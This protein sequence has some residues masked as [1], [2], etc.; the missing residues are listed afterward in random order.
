[1]VTPV[2]IRPRSRGERRSLR[3]FS[4]F[5]P[6]FRH[7]PPTPRWLGFNPDTPRRR[8]STNSASDA[9]RLH[10]DDVR[11][12]VRTLGPRQRVCDGCG[13]DTYV[14][15][16]TCHR[17]ASTADACVVTGY[18]VPAGERVTAGA[19]RPARREDWNAWTGKF[20]TDP[21]TGKEGAT[22]KH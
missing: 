4:T 13:R 22:P 16:L 6:G 12:F 10:P 2:P 5:S 21:W 17:C 14:A 7:S 3:T 8:L 18:P 11:R 15:A 9:V 19:G 20:G 1:M